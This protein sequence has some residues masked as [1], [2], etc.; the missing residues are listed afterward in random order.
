MPHYVEPIFFSLPS[1]LSIFFSEVS[2]KSFGPLFNKV[3]CFAFFFCF[4][5]SLAILDNSPL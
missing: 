1:S 2:V 4:K 3:I 5:I